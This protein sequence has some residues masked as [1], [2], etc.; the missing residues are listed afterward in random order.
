[1]CLLLPS[2]LKYAWY[3]W[4]LIMLIL[5]PLKNTP[6]IQKCFWPLLLEY[7]QM[8]PQQPFLCINN[9]A[10]QCTEQTMWGSQKIIPSQYSRVTWVQ[11]C[12]IGLLTGHIRAMYTF[13]S[14]FGFVDIS[15]LITHKMLTL[16][17]IDNACFAISS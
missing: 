9:I 3:M 15:L 1:M 16:R 6:P 17:L 5:N 2:L 12:K 7:I 11:T 4:N 10:V 8:S 13:L 14:D